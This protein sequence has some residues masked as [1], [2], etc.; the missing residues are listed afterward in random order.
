MQIRTK[1]KILVK[2]ADFGSSVRGSKHPDERRGTPLYSAPECFRRPYVSWGFKIDVWALAMVALRLLSDLP[3]APEAPGVQDFNQ[4]SLYA[5]GWG[6]SIKAHFAQSKAEYLNKPG[7]SDVFFRVLSSMFEPEPEARIGAMDACEELRE[8]VPSGYFFSLGKG[9][10]DRTPA[11]I[12][13]VLP[14]DS[15]SD[16]NSI[17][18]FRELD[19]AGVEGLPKPLL[20]LEGCYLVNLRPILKARLS[21]LKIDIEVATRQVLE[22][23][24]HTYWRFKRTDRAPE[25]YIRIE[26]AL[27]LCKGKN[28]LRRLFDVLQK[29]QTLCD[30]EMAGFEDKDFDKG[31]GMPQLS[32]V[33]SI[34]NSDSIIA[35]TEEG[36]ML[37]V[38]PRDGYIYSPSIQAVVHKRLLSTDELGN[39]S[40]YMPL[41][42]AMLVPGVMSHDDIISLGAATYSSF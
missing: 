28:R 10:A 41:D 36:R 18:R 32:L 2:V 8:D 25:T 26:D 24:K 4:N 12:E 22:L 42:G 13:P 34:S 1:N 7:A 17:F 20:M 37:L 38:R 5:D 16:D 15:R 27:E 29:Q 40:A 3:V 6:G 19:V 30:E 39:Q 9:K 23:L 14:A 11:I 21:G 33:E 35:I 31:P